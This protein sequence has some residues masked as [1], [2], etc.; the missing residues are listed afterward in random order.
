M[1]SIA[2]DMDE[3]LGYVLTDKED[4]GFGV[5]N[6]YPV[7]FVLFD[8]FDDSRT[9]ITRLQRDLQCQL[10]NADEWID[11]EF[12][13]MLLSRGE[14][15][16]HI[17][18]RVRKSGSSCIVTP[19]S[20]LARFYDN[21]RH[22]EFDSTLTTIKGIES[23]HPDAR[24]RVYI[25]I[26]GLEEKMMTFHDDPNI[27][28]WHLT[29]PESKDYMLTLTDGQTFGV[30]NLET[31]FRVIDN[32]RKWLQY[33]KESHRDADG[34]GQILCTSRSIYA[35]SGNARPDNAFDYKV[36][37]D[38]KE[39][40]TE[41]LEFGTNDIPYDEDSRQWW[42]RLA[43]DI[44]ISRQRSF[45]QYAEDLLGVSGGMSDEAFLKIWFGSA[46]S[47]DC[48]YRRWIL[49]RYFELHSDG[50][51]ATTLKTLTAYDDNQLCRTIAL[52]PLPTDAGEGVN[53]RTLCLN[54]LNDNGAT[55]GDA[56]AELVVARIR[57]FA[58]KHGENDALAHVS[59]L[60][61]QEQFLVLQ[62]VAKGLVKINDVRDV[63]PD[64]AAYLGPTSISD[65]L[66]GEAEWLTDYID[67]YKK[68]RLLG[69]SFHNQA[70]SDE[71]K[72]KITA[73]VEAIIVE[74]NACGSS[75][76][77]WYDNAFKTTKTVLHGRDDIDA[78]FW[79]DG[80]GV[81]WIP[82]VA[83]VVRSHE[84]KGFYLNEI[85]MSSAVLPSV[86]SVNKKE[87][88]DMA[89][90]KGLSKEGDLDHMA[91]EH[92]ASDRPKLMEEMETVRK[93]I[94]TALAKNAGKK[95]AI[96]SD[97]GLTY[98]SQYYP[99][100]GL[101][102]LKD[103]HHGRTATY[104]KGN[105]PASDYYVTAG[106]SGSVCALRHPSLCGK[107]PNGEG[108]HGGCTPEECLVPIF[109]VSPSRNGKLWHA[110]LLS[111]AGIEKDSVVRFRIKGLAAGAPELTYNGKPYSLSCADGVYTSEMLKLDEECR[112]VVVSIDGVSQDLDINFTLGAQ[113]DDLFGDL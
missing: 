34:G 61:W 15:V 53:V 113:E 4:G 22:K 10:I 103:D 7:R 38:V 83:E 40:L 33:W 110:A 42:G 86:T 41:G 1:F 19:F 90:D 45:A 112:K 96:V 20:E 94:S 23:L 43:A 78:Y 39:F 108:A 37:T 29:R 47:D 97:H 84:A 87:L 51:L 85:H 66:S 89:A 81:D 80:L 9:F 63:F 31:R 76:H 93:A 104:A 107:V 13:D 46:N 71:Q 48:G 24:Q 98:M 109:V 21:T 105:A 67:K 32:V 100:L 36:C 27:T 28:I 5:A 35:N 50:F 88:E 11:P 111:N 54:R 106:Q 59:R 60:T 16:E 12:N 68:S 52:M 57:D 79:I 69:A 55:L 30:R 49:C 73:E 77:K 8:T 65:E 25:P 64:L 14:L 3:L 101:S 18:E 72:S 26:I 92:K 6:R 95:I 56:D 102:N 70:I 82:F 91:H 75:F 17:S 44:D 58:E 62:W 99:G 2:N 74:K